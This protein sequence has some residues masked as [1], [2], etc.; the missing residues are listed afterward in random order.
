MKPSIL[1]KEWKRENLLSLQPSE[2]SL[3]FINFSVNKMLKNLYK[4]KENQAITGLFGA[5]ITKSKVFNPSMTDGKPLDKSKTSV[6][7]NNSHKPEA[8]NSLDKIVEVN[9]VKLETKAPEQSEYSES[10]SRQEGKIKPKDRSKTKSSISQQN[11]MKKSSFSVNKQ[12]EDEETI[13][14][15]FSDENL[16]KCVKNIKK[17][18]IGHDEYYLHVNPVILYKMWETWEDEEGNMNRDILKKETTPD[19]SGL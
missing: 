3:F 1:S 5:T 8:E 17:E 18:E 13:P 2:F 16:Q 6:D 4:R 14:D 11:S 15:L 9:D 10:F 7:L 19:T 12:K